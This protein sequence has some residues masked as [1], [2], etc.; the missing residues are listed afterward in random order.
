MAHGTATRAR[1]SRLNPIISPVG[2]PD[3]ISQCAQLVESLGHFMASN[4][5]GNNTGHVHLLTGAIAAALNFE[6]EAAHV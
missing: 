1:A 4:Q 2:Q 5:P 6:L 3:T